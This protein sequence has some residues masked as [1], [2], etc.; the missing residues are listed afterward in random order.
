[1]AEK[2]APAKGNQ[3]ENQSEGE[4]ITLVGNGTKAVENI[5]KAPAELMQRAATKSAG[6][7]RRVG[8]AHTLR[9]QHR[10]SSSHPY[11]TRRWLFSAY[12]GSRTPPSWA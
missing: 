8:I 7:F 5:S 12:K 1:M 4:L 2:Q 10:T 9:D 3:T 6:Q 11:S